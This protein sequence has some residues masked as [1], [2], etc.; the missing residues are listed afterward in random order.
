MAVAPLDEEPRR[1]FARVGEL[2]TRL[3]TVVA[4]ADW[5][6]TGMTADFED[7]IADFFFHAGTLTKPD[8]AAAKK[9]P[10]RVLYCEGVDERALVI[11]RLNN[12]AWTYE[13]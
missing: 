8:L 11:V 12:G 10:K 3:R 1:A 2:S 6:S 4:D 13:P 5:I 9:A 7:A